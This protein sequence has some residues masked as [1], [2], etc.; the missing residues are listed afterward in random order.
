M[1]LTSPSV[2]AGLRVPAGL[3]LVVVL[4]G[5]VWVGAVG[6][7]GVG[8]LIRTGLILAT[9][10]GLTMVVGLVID[11]LPGGITRA[12]WALG[13]EVMVLLGVLVT[14]L[15]ML[16]GV[17]SAEATTLGQREAPAGE[18]DR[19][20]LGND[21]LG[22][23]PETDAEA[24]AVPGPS[25]ILVLGLGSLGALGLVTALLAIVLVSVSSQA[26]LNDRQ[27]FTALSVTVAGGRTPILRI[28]NH[29]GQPVTYTLVARLGSRQLRTVRLTVNSGASE[30]LALTGV[31]PSRR[32]ERLSVVL[33]RPGRPTPYR[34]VWLRAQDGLWL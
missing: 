34:E 11:T 1:S 14:V 25:R 17:T 8:P 2:S 16:L 26:A 28:S 9:S 29:E 19:R 21:E 4:P 23:R 18:A 12:H 30:T 6:V 33:D 13:L 3:A 32:R 7:R 5:V 15:R 24:A 20:M 22:T 27:H 10:L 31:T